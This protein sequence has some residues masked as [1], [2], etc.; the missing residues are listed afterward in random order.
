MNL[1]VG[2][3]VVWKGDSKGVEGEILFIH[4]DGKHFD[5]MITNPKDTDGLFKGHIFQ[6][7]LL[8]HYTLATVPR[9]GHHLTK[10]F[11]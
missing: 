3:I 1:K 6:R 7:E 11:K 8:P 4:E 5:L 9:K 2:D 10:I